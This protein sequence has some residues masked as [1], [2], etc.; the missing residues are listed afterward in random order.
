MSGFNSR[1]E[2]RGRC[3]SG[4]IIVLRCGW[5]GGIGVYAIKMKYGRRY[6]NSYITHL[7]GE[8]IHSDRDRKIL[9]RRYVDGVCF[10]PLAEEFG[11]SVRQVKS[12]VYRAEKELFSQISE[13]E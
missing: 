12:I 10:E 2:R 5:T 3:L 4:D 11:L 1:P 8:Y 7:I 13:S 9:I 6:T